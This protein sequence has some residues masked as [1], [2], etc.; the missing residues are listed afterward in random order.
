[1]IDWKEMAAR[2]G[3]SWVE[4]ANDP[5]GG[6]PLDNLPYCVFTC[7]ERRHPRPGIRIGDLIL[8][9]A[10]ASRSGGLE[11][12]DHALLAA[13]HAHTLNK[14]IACEPAALAALRERL[15]H[16]LHKN[17]D[18]ATRDAMGVL[19]SP[20]AESTLL[21]PVDPPNFTDF[22]A[23]IDHA[24]NVGR[25]FRPALPLLPNYKFVPIGYHGRASSIVV[26][27]TGIRRP[28]GQTK[29]AAVGVPAFGPTRSLD[30]EVEVGLYMGLGNGLG[31]P[32]GIADAGEHIFGV[33]LVNDWSARDMQA[34]EYQ[35][36]GPF[37]GKS[38]A[39]SVSPWVVPIAALKPFRVPAALRAAGDP[40]PL[41]YLW[42]SD[43]QHSGAVDLVVEVHLLTPAM[44]AAGAEPHRLSRANLRD[45]YW[46]PAQLI[47]HHTSNGCNLIPSDL[48]ATGTISGPQEDSAGCLLELTHGG[49]K[50]LTLPHGERRTALEDGDEVILQAYCR[51]DGYPK[52][53]LGECRGMVL[54]AV[55]AHP[56]NVR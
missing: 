16:L 39:T 45:L 7:G 48:L 9:L 56:S 6:F 34:W 8:D 24:T 15:Q 40:D 51:R 30:Y 35:P 28:N 19:L 13:C 46:T 29:P 5:E 47:A 55:A 38:F 4:S 3:A 37:L 42:N 22:Y 43:D 10:G 33:S 21:K 12:L 14:L 53:S 11:G 25:I 20:V 44:R 1:M 18:R 52:I 27:G 23:S 32:I 36:L 31:E 2:G 54:P 49:G 50:P 41:D 26:S 17:A